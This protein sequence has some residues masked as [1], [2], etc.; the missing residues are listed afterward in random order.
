MRDM[1]VHDYHNND[2]PVNHGN[3]YNMNRHTHFDIGGR[4]PPYNRGPPF[5]IYG[6]QYQP[7]QPQPQPQPQPVQTPQSYQPQQQQPVQ[8]YPAQNPDGTRATYNPYNPYGYGWNR[9]SYGWAPRPTYGSSFSIFNPFNLFG[10]GNYRPGGWGW[11]L[12][13]NRFGLFF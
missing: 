3:A 5:G 6:P 9:P 2:G 10:F 4:N 11:G 1:R 12:G 13:G 7:Q 8:P